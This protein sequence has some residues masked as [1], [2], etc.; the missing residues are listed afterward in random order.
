MANGDWWTDTRARIAMGK[1][2]ILELDNIWKDRGVQN[3]VKM[4]IVRAFILPEIL[5]RAEAWIFR[6]TDAKQQKC[7]VYRRLFRASWRGRSKAKRAFL[8]SLTA[9]ANFSLVKK[10]KRFRI[11]LFGHAIRGGGLPSDMFVK[12]HP[13]NR[14]SGWLRRQCN[15]DNMDRTGLMLVR[16]F[17]DRRK[18]RYNVQRCTVVTKAGQPRTRGR[19]DWLTQT[20]MHRK[21]E[22]EA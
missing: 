5:Y 13:G 6:T 22:C 10:R 1:K 12:Y 8:I 2:R 3:E 19:P 20:S 18:G 14:R 16:R 4:R 9:I 21:F 15:N 7:G 11:T 17:E